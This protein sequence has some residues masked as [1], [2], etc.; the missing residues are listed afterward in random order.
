MAL[1]TSVRRSEAV[2]DFPCLRRSRS[3]GQVV[4]FSGLSE[5]MVLHPA[6]T[7]APDPIGCYATSWVK[8]T[9]E[10][11]WEPVKSIT[12]EEV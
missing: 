3:N 4:L 1:S 11:A 7:L 10:K 6:N 8:A 9:D 2:V 12:I 5:G